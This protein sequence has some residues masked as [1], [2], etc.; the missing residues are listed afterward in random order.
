ML[1]HYNFRDKE[2]EDTDQRI[3]RY[4]KDR[5]KR[6][7]LIT[8]PFPE[9]GGKYSFLTMYEDGNPL[10]EKKVKVLKGPSLLQ[11]FHHIL[12]TYYFLF[13]TGLKFDLCI[14]LENLSFVSIFPLRLLGIF[15]RLVYYSI[16]FVPQRFSNPFLNW[17]YHFMDKF[18]C[19]HSD[20]NW[21]MTKQMI[22]PRKDYEIKLSN[23][24]PFVIVPIGYNID[25]INVRPFDKI[26][27][28]SIVYAGGLRESYGPQ[29]VIKIIPSLLKKFPKIRL[30]IIGIGKYEDELKKL[31]KVLK[32]NKS[33]DFKGFIP[34]FKELTDTLAKHSVAVAPYMPVPG[35]YS[36]YSDP[37]KIKLYMCCGLPV[38]TTNVTTLSKTISKTKSGIVIE[39]SERALF[40]AMT[41]L[42]KN[43]KTYKL[44]K[45][46]AIKL[47]EGFDINVVMNP[48]IRRIP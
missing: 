11:F 9:F 21:V 43:K 44:Y 20:V 28:Y 30:T 42:L 45:E 36:Y 29:L 23:S 35:S 10:L 15:K 41:S 27:L 48:A 4:L 3:L 8:H 34:S 19:Q 24:S 12:I 39:Y 22:E 16:D 1:T 7:I 31:I 13:Y 46:A 26:D 33:I 17:F 40:K 32:I 5:V 47:S 38:I 37:S 18:A 25:D 2:G 6:V 14:A